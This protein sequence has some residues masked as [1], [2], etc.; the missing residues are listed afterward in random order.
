[1]DKIFTNRTKPFR[2]EYDMADSW[3]HEITLVGTGE[4]AE[5]EKIACVGGARACPRE[6]CGGVMGY[7]N[8]L[9]ALTHPGA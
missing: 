4:G 5:G 6:D 7:H 2:Y 3:R 1:M 8:L 9:E